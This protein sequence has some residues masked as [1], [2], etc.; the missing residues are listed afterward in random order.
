MDRRRWI[1]GSRTTFDFFNGIHEFRRV[2]LEHQRSIRATTIFCP[3]R[4]CINI[5][6]WEDFGIIEDH[7]ILEGLN[8]IIMFGIGMV[9]M[10]PWD[11]QSTMN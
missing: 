1:Y 6:R 11:N 4:E 5:K 2:A 9:R 8:K 7:F 3:F 10:I